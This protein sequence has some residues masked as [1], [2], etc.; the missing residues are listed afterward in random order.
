[1]SFMPT[2]AIQ[3]EPTHTNAAPSLSDTTSPDVQARQLVPPAPTENMINEATVRPHDNH[4]NDLPN[5]P[6]IPAVTRHIVG[7]STERKASVG[8]D[9][10]AV[11]AREREKEKE[12]EKK[13][14]FTFTLRL[15]WGR[16]VGMGMGTCAGKDKERNGEKEKTRK[17]MRR[18]FSGV[19]RCFGRV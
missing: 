16:R 2:P 7:G 12:K 4:P 6:I 13:R 3:E 14:R 11:T 19:G 15:P 9:S 10:T 1:M 17:G 8:T 18:V 5:D